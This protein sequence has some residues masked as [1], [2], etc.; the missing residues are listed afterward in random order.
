MQYLFVLLMLQQIGMYKIYFIAADYCL[1]Y[2][3]CFHTGLPVN[4]KSVFIIT[5]IRVMKIMY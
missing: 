2:A 3:E 5:M 4:D 1:C